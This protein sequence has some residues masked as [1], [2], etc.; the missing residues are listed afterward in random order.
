MITVNP[1][2]I[3]A[4]AAHYKQGWRTFEEMGQLNLAAQCDERL[5]A[6]EELAGLILHGNPN[7]FTF[8]C[9]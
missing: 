7:Y 5:V 2:Q 9:D 8:D 6:L 3:I 4:I 1:W